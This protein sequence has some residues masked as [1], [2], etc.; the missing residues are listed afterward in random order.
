M[1]VR[2]V[3]RAPALAMVYAGLRSACLLLQNV[4]HA[5]VQHSTGAGKCCPWHREDLVQFHQ[6]RKL[7][8]REEEEEAWIRDAF[9]GLRETQFMVFRSSLMAS[10][11]P[12]LHFWFN[13]WNQCIQSCYETNMGLHMAIIY[14][15]DLSPSCRQ[16]N[17]LRR[18]RKQRGWQPWTYP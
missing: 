2:P 16:L 10:D 7:W 3:D 9:R 15:M 17:V 4:W 18:F 12:L 1:L 14:E 8:L 11:A 13:A 5:C 6:Q